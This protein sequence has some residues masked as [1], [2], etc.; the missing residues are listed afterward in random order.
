MDDPNEDEDTVDP[1]ER[2]PMRLLDSLVQPEGELSDSEDEGEGGR[3]DHA[4]HRD[5][6]SI[7]TGMGRRFGVGVGIMG[8]AAPGSGSAAGSGGPS[9]H[10]NIQSA[11]AGSSALTT[12]EESRS[13]AM[14]VDEQPVPSVNGNGKDVSVNGHVDDA[15]TSVSANMSAA[16]DERQSRN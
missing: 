13:D 2:R 1:D 8:A 5:S 6:D 16:A 15:E 3:R 12:D 10:T 7:S 14:D 9:A 11:L 4:R